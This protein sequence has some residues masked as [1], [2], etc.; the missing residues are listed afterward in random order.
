MCDIC[1]C[2]NECEGT[3]FFS[4]IQTMKKKN[5]MNP[6]ND[7][8]SVG[9]VSI[10]SEKKSPL[11]RESL[12]HDWLTNKFLRSVNPSQSGAVAKQ[13]FSIFLIYSSNLLEISTRM[14]RFASD[15]KNDYQNQK[16]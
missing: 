3:L 4:N 8:D 15:S 12:Q 11:S 2:H 13:T 1:F 7:A 14:I 6:H 10:K 16:E 5:K 9:N